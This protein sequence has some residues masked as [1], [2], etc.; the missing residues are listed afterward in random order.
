MERILYIGL[1]IGGMLLPA[2][3]DDRDA[4]HDPSCLIRLSTGIT[5]DTRAALDRFDG[6]TVAFAKATASGRYTETWQ[7]IATPVETRLQGEHTYPADRSYL[8]LRGY[9]PVQSLSGGE[10][11]YKLD[12]QTDLM[13][14][15]EQK[16]SL[17]DNFSLRS[18]TFYFNHLLTQVSLEVR[19]SGDETDVLRLISIV[20]AGSRPQAGIRLSAAPPAELP[21]VDFSG[22]PQP[23]T[24]YVEPIRGG[25]ILLSREV[26]LLPHTLLVE[27]GAPLTLDIRAGL[28][29]GTER[30][31]LGMPVRF[32][33]PDGASRPG[34]AYRLTVTLFPP[35]H[36][37][38]DISAGAA[39][40]PWVDGKG[41][42]TVE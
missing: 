6:E 39:V 36:S 27:P 5:A 32:D 28:P 17:T 16:G 19:T 11:T 31:W 18:K 42:G 10:V 37:G 29:D 8:Y 14:T 26:A 41:S 24:A 33:E 25:G 13:A 3:S 34:T 23:L 35:G 38:P 22:E 20:V 9:Y 12:G 4:G 30:R 40:V 21:P 1:L 15:V 7:A 2:C